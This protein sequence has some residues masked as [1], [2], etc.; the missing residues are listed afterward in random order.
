MFLLDIRYDDGT[1]TKWIRDDAGT[2]P[3]KEVYYPGIY[4]SC[5]PE[6]KSLVASLPG[7][8]EVHVEK[9]STSL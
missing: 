3:V 5:K 1:I 9:K 7:V 6:M 8:R 4:L 2:R